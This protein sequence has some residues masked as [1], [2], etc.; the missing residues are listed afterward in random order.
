MSTTPILKQYKRIKA[1]HKNELL[2]F[3][4]GDFYEF[5]Y[6]DAKIASKILGIALTSKPMGKG[7][8]VPLAGIPVKA[9][10]GYISKLLQK[11]YKVAIC[12]QVG[13]NN[14]GLMERKVVEIITPGT[15]FSPTLLEDKSHNYIAA[16]YRNENRAGVAYCDITT[17]D[18]FAFEDDLERAV[19]ELERI[20]A[21]EV[22]AE[23]EAEL[24][25]DNLTP[26]DPYEFEYHRARDELKNFFGISTLD[27]LELEDDELA[28]RASGALIS[29]LLE[30]KPGMLEHI[31]GIKKVRLS[32]FMYIDPQ[33]IKNLEIVEKIRPE[34]EEM[35]LFDI[36]DRCR[37]PMGSRRLKES[38]LSPFLSKEQILKRLSRINHLV[39][40]P[41][42]LQE[43]QDI[44][45]DI[46]DIERQ[47]GRISANKTNPR[48]LVRFASSLSF[49]PKLVSL[50]SGFEEWVELV[51]FPDIGGVDKEILD[52]IV[53]D[54]PV[55]FNL[56]G[57]VRDGVNKE[58]DELRDISKHGKD[59]L[60][61]LEQ[62]ERIR[63]GIGNLRI[64]YNSVFGYYI[65]V[66]KS[67][68]HLVPDDYVRKQTLT[69][70]ERFITE[71]LKQLEE[72]ILGAEERAIR[73]ENEIVRQ[74]REKV[75]E[76]SFAIKSIAEKI[77][78][79]D[80]IASLAEVA[81]KR[82]YVMPEIKEDGRIEIKDGRHP[83]VEAALSAESFIP[84]DTFMDLQENRIFI[85]TGPNMSGKSTYLRQVALITIMAHIGSFVPASSAK[86]GL[87]DRI[88]SRIGASDDLARGISTFMAEMIETAQILH[89]ATRRSLIILD[90]VGR[91]TS[92]FDGLAIAWAVV[93]YLADFV[94]A[95]TLFATHYHE[96]S[97]LGRTLKGVRNYTIAVKEWGD[98]IIFLRK[99]IPGESDRSYG[100]HVAKLAGIPS[101]VIKR[102]KEILKDL[103]KGR[104]S[105]KVKAREETL[106]L[107]IFKK[108]ESEKESRLIEMLKGV[109]PDSLSPRE[110]L[111]LIYQLK[112]ELRK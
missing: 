104:K 6:D 57:V 72:K 76:K 86:I 81:V 32:N 74:L 38:L 3:R 48:E 50:L 52:T 19:T 61:E 8:R 45:S 28:V 96:L 10:D 62:R 71:E 110:A 35:T 53:D 109:D 7:I 60:L 44:L 59:K 39:M 63:T 78:E 65:E 106:Q 112:E 75:L 103:G 11:G 100:I 30:K 56:G 55:N 29:Y 90:E 20:G 5:F 93:E 108:E 83:V 34:A 92:T 54:P 24:P 64:G 73:L 42:L 89:N 85:I 43:L 79:I 16:I 4:M 26:R 58:L 91:G 94:G 41:S 2:L 37:T 107:D 21:S 33:T 23:E 46:T 95:K 9:A 1:E 69:N 47:L 51:D 25:F 17:G 87:V 77:A 84:N 97:I 99:L 40:N 101:V 70:S 36:L 68:L 18:F 105:L 82:K 22:L 102:A 98:E 15:V 13:E 111:E 80:L 67:N 31:K 14:S 66:T 88:F 49:T 27:P 12:E